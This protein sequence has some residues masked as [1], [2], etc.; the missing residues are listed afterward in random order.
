[1]SFDGITHILHYLV[2]YVDEASSKT[3]ERWCRRAHAE[4]TRAWDWFEHEL[5]CH[6]PDI[7]GPNIHPDDVAK[8]LCMI[9]AILEALS[10]FVR[11]CVSRHPRPLRHGLSFTQIHTGKFGDI[12]REK[13]LQDG[14]CP[15]AIEMLSC[16]GII[17]LAYAYRCGPSSRGDILYENDNH[18]RCT[19][20]ECMRNAIDIATYSNRHVTGTCRCEYL[21]PPK[22]TVEQ[23]ILNGD[24]PVIRVQSTSTDQSPHSLQPGADLQYDQNG[25]ANNNIEDVMPTVSCRK[26][27]STPYVAI[28]HVWA[29]GLGS[30]TEKGLPLCLMK[31]LGM[32]AGR[33]VTGGAFWIDSLCV[34]RDKRTRALAIGKMAQIYREAEVVLVIDSGIQRCSLKTPYTEIKLRIATSGWMQ[35]VW[36]LQEACLARKLVFKLSDGYMDMKDVPGHTNQSA[37]ARLSKILNTILA[38]AHK[39]ASETCHC[40]INDISH[41]L[42]WRNIGRAHDETLAIAALLYVDAKELVMLPPES[43]MAKLLLSVRSMHSSVVFKKG[44]KIKVPGFRWASRSLIGHDSHFTMACDAIC[45]DQGLE[46]SYPC[47][48]FEKTTFRRDEVWFLRLGKRPVTGGC[49]IIMPTQDDGGSDEYTCDGIIVPEVPDSGD[50]VGGAVLLCDRD[51]T[52]S[53]AEDAR[54][55]AIWTKR[56]YVR[57]AGYETPKLHPNL[58]VIKVRSLGK[59]DLLLT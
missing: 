25:E 19:P 10:D 48:C 38:P 9:A 8:I 32:M 50:T 40:S 27:S 13:L 11:H 20:T 28:S 56:L 34:P 45:T 21:A 43:R 15:F 4:L 58:R 54:L 14:W 59:Q 36:T 23:M 1:M 51:T 44:P 22:N 29:D 55:A 31:Q 26:S 57:A 7:S 12:Y 5:E 41:R 42:A 2:H 39:S 24:I 53:Q 6:E 49:F 47:I 16:A 37:D 52:R 18:K 46:T 33:L 30:T 35:R 17:P 3:L